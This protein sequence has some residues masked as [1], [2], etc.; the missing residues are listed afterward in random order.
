MAVTNDGNSQL[1]EDSLARPDIHDEWEGR[2][3]EADIRAFQEETLARLIELVAPAPGARF[4]D[5]GCGTGYNAIQ[6]ARLGF[7]VVACD[8]SDEVLARARENVREA[9][10][11]ESVELRR[12]NLLELGLPDASAD[13]VVCWGVLMHIPEVETAISELARVLRPGGTLIVCE[14]NVH[15]LDELA[16]RVL[17]RLGRT[18]SRERVPAGMERWRETPAGPLFAR[19]TD[20][21]WLIGAVRAARARVEAPAGLPA[22]RGLHL[23]ASGLAAPPRDPGAQPLLV[24][25]GAQRPSRERQLPDLREAGLALRHVVDAVLEPVRGIAARVDPKHARPARLEKG[26]HV[27]AR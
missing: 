25:E 8:F 22:H 5:A 12:E 24:Q 23:H 6:L 11:E 9:G 15:A 14:G 13:V 1:V 10:V 7:P 2:Y 16:L 26:D 17:D 19:R 4:L 3:R 27:P 21:R 20:V 18:V